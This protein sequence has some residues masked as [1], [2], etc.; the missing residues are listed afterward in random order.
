MTSNAIDRPRDAVHGAQEPLRVAVVGAGNMGAKWLRLAAASPL[1]EVVAVVDVDEPR[2]RDVLAGAGL[3]AARTSPVLSDRLGTVDL[4]INTTIPAAHHEI[5]RTA[6][7]MGAHVVSEK[8]AA[9]DLADGLRL[10]GV[11]LRTGR[12]LS[13]SQSRSLTPGVRDLAEAARAAAHVGMLQCTLAREAR[14]GGFREQMAHP[15]LV[16][17]A[18]HAFDAARVITGADATAVTCRESN[19]PWSWY[20]G[21]SEAVATFEMSNGSLFVFTG[22]WTSLGA[23]TS[24]NGSWRVETS[25]GVLLWDGESVPQRGAGDGTTAPARPEEGRHGIAAAFDEIVTAALGGP[26]PTGAVLR[27]LGSLAMVEAAV[28]SSREERRV[29]LGEVIDRAAAEAGSR[30]TDRDVRELLGE[31]STRLE[32]RAGR[33]TG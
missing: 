20:E 17:M 24:W 5:S 25:D 13:V 6:M 7:E 14:F 11:S 26:T 29:R 27:N 2:A 10:A 28:L 23:P 31:V 1:T 33:G 22:T 8:P 9:E 16:D 15:L 18:V 30:E 12:L 4:V 32:A 3:A 21:S 19:P